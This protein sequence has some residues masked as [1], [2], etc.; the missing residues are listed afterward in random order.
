MAE[1]VQRGL[2]R[3]LPELERLERAGLLE[4]A[5]RRAVIRKV[6]ALEHRVHRRVLSK[7]NF[8]SYI[9]YEINFL[10]LVKKRRAKTGYHFQ[11]EEIEYAI[12][13]RVH[14]L[15]QRALAKWKGDVQLWL[16]HVAFCKKWN[17]KVRL[18]KVFTAML[19]I[20]PD[21]PELWIMA[22]KW[23]ME[24][25]LSSHNARNLFLRALRYHPHTHKLHHEYFRMELMHAEK[26]RNEEECLETATVEPGDSVSRGDIGSGEL[27]RLVYKNAVQTVTGDADFHVSFWNIAALFT[28]TSRLQD[29]ILADLREQHPH[30][31]QTWDFLARRE[32][33]Q[34]SAAGEGG[35]GTPAEQPRRSSNAA[36]VARKE[37]RCWDMY[38]QA[39][40]AVPTAHMWKCYVTFC[41]ERFRRKTNNSELRRQRLEQLLSVLGRAQDTAML[42]PDLHRTWL[43]LLV[44]SGQCERAL[45]EAERMCTGAGRCLQTW[46]SGLEVLVEQ[47]CPRVAALVQQA[48]REVPPAECLPL[49]LLYLEW[50]ETNDCP[51]HTETL[52]QMAVRS[53]VPA[54]SVP[55]KE[56]YL[57]WGLRT[58]GYRKAR[59]VF[60]RLRE[61]RP[62]SLEFFR[63]MI[64]IEKDQGGGDMHRLREYYE[65]AV[66]EFGS[67]TAGLWLDYIGEERRHEQGKAEHSG[68]LHWRAMKAL[69]GPE[70]ESFVSQY[71]LLQTGHL[72]PTAH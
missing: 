43:A 71:T 38:E 16:S 40:G 33:V 27:A 35:A 52:Y 61:E 55:V 32:L 21:K 60:A 28:F 56:Q 10:Q 53:V 54:V 2:E 50:S 22:A 37:Q 67:T 23:E 69:K 13:N 48:L 59:L 72:E 64:A 9:Q 41:H 58:G 8:I 34:G 36:E 39:V 24:E 49:W 20:H 65:R 25:R 14:G 29:D 31:T 11:K 51:D 44:G 30:R 42:P 17:A 70:V 47:G 46:Q 12:V 6:T 45:V 4:A 1:L 66:R 68:P 62:F 57:D 3:R 63:K 26:V 7:D 15:F 19:S 5:E 18:S